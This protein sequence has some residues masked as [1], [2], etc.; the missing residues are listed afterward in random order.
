MF[1]KC[2]YKYIQWSAFWFA[3]LSPANSRNGCNTAPH[4]VVVVVA[5]AATF[6]FQN[7]NVLFWEENCLCPLKPFILLM[8]WLISLDISCCDHNQP[9]S[10]ADF[11]AQKMD[12]ATTAEERLWWFDWWIWP[13]LPKC[14]N[15]IKISLWSVDVFWI[16]KWWHD[17]T[18]VKRRT[19]LLVDD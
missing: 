7:Q 19:F 5:A 3:F 11:K 9:H 14:L 18:S 16:G 2:R 10:E 15:S 12:C 4:N 13:W 1:L 6:D 17:G 8:H